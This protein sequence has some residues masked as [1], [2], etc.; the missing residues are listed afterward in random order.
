MLNN[1][2]AIDGGE[3]SRAIALAGYSHC[4]PIRK[5]GVSYY[6]FEADARDVFITGKRA[7]IARQVRKLFGRSNDRL[8][9]QPVVAEL[10][11][12]YVQRKRQLARRLCQEQTQQGDFSR[13]AFWRAIWNTEQAATA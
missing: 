10:P 6:P 1:E 4:G 13:L 9:P 11:E 2:H 5:I 7:D 8:D 3:I 12:C